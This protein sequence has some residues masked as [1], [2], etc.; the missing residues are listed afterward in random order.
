MKKLVVVLL[1]M[2]GNVFAAK[3]QDIRLN[4]YGG[5]LF[6]DRFDSYFD[7]SSYY[8]GKLK[9]GF[10]WGGGLEYM[11]HPDYGIELLYL[12]L[13]TKAPTTYF[14]NGIKSANFDVGI[15]YLMISGNRYIDTDN[16]K[17]EPYGGAMFGAG[18]IA[19]K[20]PDNG[21]SSTR[22]KF[23]WG[24]KLGTNIWAGKK[25]GIKIQAQLF[26]IVQA[27]GGSFYFGTGGSGAGLETYSSF[28]QFGL[29]G[30]LVYKLGK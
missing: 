28:L 13:D 24:T 30:G 11:A 9:G 10:Q 12:R 21:N 8:R 23:A 14:S 26:S 2:T 20:N 25:L 1:I 7:A 6:D 29:G 19:V 15:N 5:Y 17:I 18:I 16:K 22:T 3:A 27:F 4:L